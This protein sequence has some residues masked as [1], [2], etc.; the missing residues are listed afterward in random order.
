MCECECV[1]VSLSL[2]LSL[3]LSPFR[4]PKSREYIHTYLPSEVLVLDRKK[5]SD[6]EKELGWSKR[7]RVTRS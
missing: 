4:L 2:S 3:S 5:R 6:S 1:R 7:K